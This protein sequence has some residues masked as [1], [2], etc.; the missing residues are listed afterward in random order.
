[1]AESNK[2]ER[3]ARR[4]K[5]QEWKK[6]IDKQDSEKEN[7]R[8]LKWGRV[9]RFFPLPNISY[10]AILLTDKRTRKY[11]IETQY[12]QR[13]KR[14]DAVHDGQSQG[15]LTIDLW[16]LSIFYAVTNTKAMF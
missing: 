3:N 1:V 4:K 10:P 11:C 9:E 8:R 7:V 13:S 16:H 2:L 12:I 5:E 14:I 15:N 6:K